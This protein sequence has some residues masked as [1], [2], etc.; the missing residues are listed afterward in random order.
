MEA[1]GFDAYVVGS[2]EN[3][4]YVSGFPMRHSSVN[5]APFVL[6]NQYPAFCI[7]DGEGEVTLIAWLA[8]L[9]ER[10]FDLKEVLP[11]VDRAGALEALLST[12]GSLRDSELTIG[13]DDRF[14]GF[15]YSQL[16]KDARLKIVVD[17]GPLLALRLRKSTEEK[18]RILS[19]TEITENAIESLRQSMKEGTSD[20]EII[21]RSKRTMLELGADMW[22]HAT[23]P[24]EDSNPEI[25]QGRIAKRGDVVGLDLGAIFSGYCSDTHRKFAIGSA[26]QAAA[27]LQV[28]LAEF[29]MKCGQRLRPGARFSEIYEYASALYEEAGMSFV[30]PN[31]GHS[32]GI[33]TEEANLSYDSVLK[34][35]EDMVL[36]IELY[37]ASENG[38]FMGLE[39]T[40]LVEAGT[41]R[42]VTK[43]PQQLITV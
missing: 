30:F 10:D 28:R 27:D 12:I 14:P 29:V 38:H 26:D 34:V 25:P 11:A 5:S 8:A 24:I 7:I 37:G 41:P 22:D 9:R 18:R 3:V 17:E 42:R 4:F 35:E 39:D 16:T 1:S 15:A 36:N 2:A 23:I 21:S 32:V 13:V 31:V 20:L 6:Q 33:Q 19:A 43:L 40:F